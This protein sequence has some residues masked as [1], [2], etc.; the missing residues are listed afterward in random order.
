M[1]HHQ[2][3][4]GEVGYPKGA[5]TFPFPV[6]QEEAETGDPDKSAERNSAS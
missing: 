6:E 3:E 1:R 5:K 4:K 2:S